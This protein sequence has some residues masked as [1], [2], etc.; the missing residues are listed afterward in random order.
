MPVNSLKGFI[1]NVRDDAYFEK[2]KSHL[3]LILLSSNIMKKMNIRKT[4]NGQNINLNI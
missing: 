4:R 2:V 1:I 3:E